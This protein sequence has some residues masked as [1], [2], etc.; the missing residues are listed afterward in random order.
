MSKKYKLQPLGRLFSR[1]E[2]K[3]RSYHFLNTPEFAF[4]N[5]FRE[6]KTYF[7]GHKTPLIHCVFIDQKYVLAHMARGGYSFKVNRTHFDLF[8]PLNV[9]DK[10]IGFVLKIF[11]P[12]QALFLMRLHVT[13]NTTKSYRS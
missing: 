12:C 8:L 9:Y 5:S 7:W 1:T 4:G 3:A 13:L 10:V 6:K 11:W 2:K